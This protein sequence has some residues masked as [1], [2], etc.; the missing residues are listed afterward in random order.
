MVNSGRLRGS[1]GVGAGLEGEDEVVIMMIIGGIS[2]GGVGWKEEKRI[3][4]GDSLRKREVR[5]EGS[6]L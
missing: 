4:R 5:R 2:G 6:P 3:V 1:K